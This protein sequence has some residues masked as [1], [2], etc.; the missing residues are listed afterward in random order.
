[1]QHGLSGGAYTLEAATYERLKTTWPRV[2]DIFDAKRHFLRLPAQ[3]L[4]EGGSR[5]RADDAIVDYSIGL[6]ALLIAGAR[7]E[8]TYR[9]ALR[10]ATVIG[11]DDQKVKEHFEAL[12]ALY[13]TRSKIVHGDSL[14]T[15]QLTQARASGEYAL[16]QVW[17]WF[18]ENSG[19]DVDRGVSQIDDRILQ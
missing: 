18:F 9:F 7:D 6:E 3:R 13:R 17:W 4:V 14:D 11:W 15:G 2:R 19:S 10:G 8:L 5:R 12:R 16:R 1:M